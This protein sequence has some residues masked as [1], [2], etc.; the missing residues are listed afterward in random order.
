[1]GVR[2]LV[3]AL[4]EIPAPLLAGQ[5]ADRPRILREK[6]QRN[7]ELENP[8]HGVLDFRVHQAGHGMVDA[9]LLAVFTRQPRVL[10]E[11]VLRARGIDHVRTEQRP[12]AAELRVIGLWPKLLSH[13]VSG[14]A[15]LVSAQCPLDGKMSWSTGKKPIAFGANLSLELGT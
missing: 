13:P 12:G 15:L 8:F 7:R 14:M 6:R 9:Y 3:A 4:V 1:M 2:R 10:L 11:P 5:V